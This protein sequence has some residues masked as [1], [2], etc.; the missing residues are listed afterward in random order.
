MSVLTDA[1]LNSTFS[2]LS[3]TNGDDVVYFGDALR[4]TAGGTNSVS[5]LVNDTSSS[6]SVSS[7]NVTVVLSRPPLLRQSLLMVVVLTLA[8]AAVF[9]LAVVNNLLVVTVIYRNPALR[10]VTNYFLTNLAVADITV[11]F[12]V[13]PVTLLSNLFTGRTA[14]AFATSVYDNGWGRGIG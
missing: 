10:T 14:F 5:I 3:V 9:L 2:P 4:H 11:S 1:L 8:Y 12:I 7:S 13:L 6:S